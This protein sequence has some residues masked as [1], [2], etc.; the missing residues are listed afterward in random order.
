MTVDDVVAAARRLGEAFGR[1]VDAAVRAVRALHDLVEAWREP[2]R[3]LAEHL[4]RTRP[5][6]M[7]APARGFWG[8]WRDPWD[9]PWGMRGRRR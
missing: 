1:L 4:A 9:E 7:L 8:P 2:A 6:P 3:H 5:A